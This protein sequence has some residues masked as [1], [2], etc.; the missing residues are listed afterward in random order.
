[1]ETA[2][3]INYKPKRVCSF[4][5]G[6][7]PNVNKPNGFTWCVKLQELPKEKAASFFVDV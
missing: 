3:L 4:A 7:T 2:E 6:F 5:K 1:V